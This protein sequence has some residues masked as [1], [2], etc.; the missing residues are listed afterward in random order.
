MNR[1]G[2]FISVA[3]A[4][5]AATARAQDGPDGLIASPEAGWPQWRG[6]RRD[7]I[8]AEK[9]LLPTW[10]AEGPKL[11]WKAGGLG[12]G[13]STPIVTGGTVYVT[14]DVEDDLVIFAFDTD[15]KP[16]W[17]TT[18]GRAWKGSYPGARASLTYSEGMLYHM[19][20]HGR[21][22]ALEPATGKEVWAVNV[23]ER[24]DA[25]NITWAIAECVLVDGGRIIVTPGG[26]KAL[27][28]A[29]DKRTGDTI[30]TTPGGEEKAT[31]TS[32]ILLRHGERRIIVNCTS[33]HAI[34]VDADNGKLLWKTPL[35][36]RYG[37]TCSTPVY[38][39]G[40]VFFAAPDGPNGVMH[41]IG[42]DGKSVEPAWTTQVDTLTSS[43]IYLDGTLFASG[44][45]N[46]KTL[47]ALDWKT[48]QER[49]VIKLTDARSPY[50][51]VAMVWADGRLYCQVEEGTVAML[52]PGPEGIEVAGKFTLVD[53]RRPG[54]A[55]AHPVL[56]DGK[57]YLRYHDT[58][59]CYAVR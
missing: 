53:A 11:L 4:L 55:W 56:L 6:A 23:L 54:D 30:W 31:Y 52:K 59:W 1:S 9:N 8:S 10:P 19:N 22:A 5:L 43:G 46:S 2:V 49:H 24:F 15:G 39:D 51:A 58:I 16:K 45:K 44:S 13:W 57:L 40:G 33:H 7:S 37:S 42:P 38:G 48:G 3:L 20:A 14:G 25:R 29:L 21:L 50:A 28:A 26:T 47:Y 27:M 12:R 18:N 34:G 35:R 17:K 41:R 36:N 32:P